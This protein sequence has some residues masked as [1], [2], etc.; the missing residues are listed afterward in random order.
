VKK[1]EERKG[2]DTSLCQKNKT[3]CRPQGYRGEAGISNPSETK[4]SLEL[5]K[6]GQLIHFIKGKKSEKPPWKPPN[7]EQARKQK[8]YGPILVSEE[9]L[10]EKSGRKGWGRKK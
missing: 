5:P 2:G 4:K 1:K 9:L 10:K 8:C 6:A 7:W 3:P